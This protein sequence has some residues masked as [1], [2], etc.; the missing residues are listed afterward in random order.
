MSTSAQPSTSS[1]LTSPSMTLS[2]AP[3]LGIAVLDRD[4]TELVERAMAM[5]HSHSPQDAQILAGVYGEL[6]ATS[7]LL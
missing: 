4:E 5:V 6:R 3:A 2:A 7:E 1:V